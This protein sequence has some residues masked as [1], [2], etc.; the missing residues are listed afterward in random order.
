MMSIAAMG[1]RTNEVA[2]V[3]EEDTVETAM[4]LLSEYDVIVIN[5]YQGPRGILR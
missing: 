5:N 1:A 2:V 4:K 3:S